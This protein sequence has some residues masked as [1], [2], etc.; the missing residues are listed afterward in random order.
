MNLTSSVPSLTGLYAAAIGL[1][2]TSKDVGTLVAM[3]QNWNL[4]AAVW[5]PMKA[6]MA[7]PLIY[8]YCNGIRHLVSACSAHVHKVHTTRA[9]STDYATKATRSSV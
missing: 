6:A 3:V 2:C 7:F 9:G 8:H 1:L 5:F 4:G